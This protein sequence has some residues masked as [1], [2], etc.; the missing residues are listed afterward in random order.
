[1]ALEDSAGLRASRSRY[2]GY[3]Q[4]LRPPFVLRGDNADGQTY[5]SGKLSVEWCRECER[6]SAVLSVGLCLRAR[7]PSAS[8]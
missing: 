7:L 3:P 8:G 6:T 1:M 5:W 2:I 4:A